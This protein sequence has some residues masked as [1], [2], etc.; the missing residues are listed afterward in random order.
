MLS[1]VG[2]KMLRSTVGK[3]GINELYAGRCGRGR[4]TKGHWG[5]LMRSGEDLEVSRGFEFL[6]RLF[7]GSPMVRR[8]CYKLVEASR[9]GELVSLGTERGVVTQC[10]GQSNA[11]LACV[12]FLQV[13]GN[14]DSVGTINLVFESFEDRSIKAGGRNTTRQAQT[15]EIRGISV[16]SPLVRGTAITV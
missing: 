9:L 14:L 6:S 16:H 10:S 13:R 5:D 3:C 11:G 4:Q 7:G 2:T 8:L 1:G 15:R 12:G